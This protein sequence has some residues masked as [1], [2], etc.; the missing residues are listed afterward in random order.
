M[1]ARRARVNVPAMSRLVALALVVV[2]GLVAACGG[3]KPAAPGTAPPGAASVPPPAAATGDDAPLTLWPKVKKGTLPNGLTYYVMK[4]GQPAKRAFLWLAVNAGSVQE[5]DDQRGLAHFVEHM[6]FNGTAR[7]PKQDIVNYLES[8]G[9]S[10]GAHLNAY[11]SFD[12]TVYQLQVPTDDA[13]YVAKG[14]DILRDWAG[15]VAFDAGE[16]D[17]ERGV[18]LEEWRLGRGAGQRLFDKQSKVLFAG[19]RYAERLPIG[20]PDTLKS[21]PR[22]ALARFYADWYRPDLMAV[23]AVGDFDDP[24]AIEREIAAKFG[25][26][27]DRRAGG[28]G[29]T[30]RPRPAGGVPARGATRVSIETDREM[31]VQIVSVYNMLPH[32]PEATGRDFRR[33]VVEQVYTQI[34]NERFGTLARRP[35]APF[36]GAGAGI[37][38]FTRDIDAFTRTAQ[39]KGGNV[40]GA[41]RSL[42]VEVQRVERHGVTQG[43]LERARAVIARFIDQAAVGESTREST[44]FTDEITRNFFEG[45][46]MIGRVAESELTKR[47]LPTIT[48]A[49]LDRLAASFGG[50]DNRAIVIAGPDGQPL[51]DRA[52]VLAIVDEVARTPVAPWEDKATAAALMAKAPAPGAVKAEVTHAAI[53][54]TEWK[55]ANGARVLVKPTDF[56]KDAVILS[57]ISPG[58]LATATAK[59]FRD[60]RFADDLVGLGGA[61]ELDADTL[62]KLLAGKALQVSASIG[63][64]TEDIDA[65][66]SVRDLETMLQ[67][68]HLAFTAPRKDDAQIAIW[69]ANTVEQLT[70]QLRVPEVQFA[71]KSGEVLWKGNA[72]RRPP[73]PAEIQAIDADQALAFYKQRFGDATDFTFIIVGAV[74]VAKLR[75]LVETYLGSLPAKGRVEKEKD[76]GVRRVGGVVK[77]TWHLGSEPKARVSITFHGAEPWTRDKQRD[78]YVLGQVL[79]MRLRETLREDLGGVYG[80]GASGA[81]GRGP[82]QERTFT[83]QFGADP[84]RVDELIAA[85]HKEIAALQRGGIGA[86]YLDKVKATFVREREVQLRSNAFWASTLENAAR[87]GDDPALVLDPSP[88][89]ARMTSDH[90]KAAAKRFLDAKQYYQAVMLPAKP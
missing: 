52:R 25:D 39:V 79:G 56:E 87:Y 8:I 84:A 55:L 58:G 59:Q 20:L 33:M 69:K 78:M 7:F 60:A 14:F 5:D 61:G 26:L 65:S 66:G 28:A 45:E 72:R 75:P 23:I 2:V 89:V 6:A 70:N 19:T 29:G 17:K 50:A 22:A 57:A 1:R 77:K 44:E 47:Y 32:R 16:I 54:V 12:E 42:F 34:L 4:H 64:T 90:V 53:G 88:V 51:P 49:E 37:Q 3:S 30:A 18:V 11:T 76:S 43:E 40:E 81:I 46:L 74:D 31:P 67:L 24:A 85:V 48:L 71:R 83:I 35:D 27:P 38:S 13:T 63:E 68:I 9:M 10:F 82:T 41:L 62:Q 73:E 86:E 36:P 80:V 15:A 21:A